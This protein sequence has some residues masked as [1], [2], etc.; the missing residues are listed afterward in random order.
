MPG[1]EIGRRFE[2]HS[3]SSWRA[4]GDDI[5]WKQAHELAQ[6]VND[7]S[8]AED[9]VSGVAVL[10]PL[11]IKVEPEGESLRIRN[12]IGRHEPR[13]H[14]TERVA[15]FALNPLAC[16][17]ELPFSLGDIVDDAVASDMR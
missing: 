11:S 15:G 17:F 2:A 6:I 9:H 14:R 8:D 5:A 13:A 3:D 4:C 1:T 10:D 12:L 16:A 7:E